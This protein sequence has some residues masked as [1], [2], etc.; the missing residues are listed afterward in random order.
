MRFTLLLLVASSSAFT[1]T[2]RTTQRSSALNAATLDMRDWNDESFLMQVARNC[3]YSDECSLEEAEACLDNVIRI[4]SD[5]SSGSLVGSEVC[6]EVTATA[7]VVANLRQKIEIQTKRLSVVTAGKTVMNISMVLALAA[8]AMTGMTHTD[9]A[10]APF[11]LQE[12]WWSVRDGY[13]P[14]LLKEYYTNGGFATE[15]F[16]PEA[17]S[18]TMQEL[19]WAVKGG[20]APELVSHYFKNG[21]LMTGEDVAVSAVPFTLQEWG[22]AMQGGFLDQMLAQ[23]FMNGGLTETSEVDTVPLTA[24]E[25]V[26]AAQGGYLD[27]LIK[28]YVQNGGL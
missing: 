24:Q 22:F 25:V 23:T 27:T 26:W 7:D 18:F 11:T 28:S 20:Y 6:E 4:Q 2:V 3:A 1:S 9:P 17:T 19:W 15:N 8:V 16:V 5:C 10:V 21:G 14:L 12:V 13:L